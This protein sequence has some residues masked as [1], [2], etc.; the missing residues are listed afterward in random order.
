MLYSTCI[1]K[2]KKKIF[3]GIKE[4]MFGSS[5]LPQM[6]TYLWHCFQICWEF[7]ALADF[8]HCAQHFWDKQEGKYLSHVPVDLKHMRGTCSVGAQ[9]TEFQN[10][11]WTQLLLMDFACRSGEFLQ[12]TPGCFPHHKWAPHFL[13]MFYGNLLCSLVWVHVWGQQSH[14]TLTSCLSFQ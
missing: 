7:L 9:V 6:F 11:N 13:P 3:E 10:Q 1:Y 12:A 2:N 5:F 8:S 14:L 4:L